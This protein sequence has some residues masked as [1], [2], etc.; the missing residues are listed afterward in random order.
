MKR[1]WGR[2]EEEMRRRWGECGED[3]EEIMHEE[4]KQGYRRLVSFIHR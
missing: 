3:E 2:D 1:R 4:K